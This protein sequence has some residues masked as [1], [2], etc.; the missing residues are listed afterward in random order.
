MQY[1]SMYGRTTNVVTLFLSYSS[2]S[3][4][5]FLGLS[6][7]TVEA[8][9]KALLHQNETF[10]A[11]HAFGNSVLETGNNNNLK[12]ISKCN[13]P[14]YGRDFREGKPTGSGHNEILFSYFATQL[15]KFHYDVPSYTDLLLRWASAFLKSEKLPSSMLRC[16]PFARTLGEGLDR[17]CADKINEAVQMFNANLSSEIASLNH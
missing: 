17:K 7:C 16:L 14:P 10:L 15:R 11:I 8:A 6:T 1:S 13:F 12:T 5:I 2:F 4:I 3:M 9:F